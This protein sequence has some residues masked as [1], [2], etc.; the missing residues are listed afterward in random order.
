MNPQECSKMTDY[1]L[2]VLTKSQVSDDKEMAKSTLFKRYDSYLQVVAHR[3]MRYAVYKDFSYTVD[4]VKSYFI[5]NAF[6][7]SIDRVK[8]HKINKDFQLKQRMSWYVAQYK[9]YLARE[10]KANECKRFSE[11]IEDDPS[12]DIRFFKSNKLVGEQDFTEHIA[13]K[14]TVKHVLN[15]YCTIEEKELY[16]LITGG[17]TSTEIGRMEGVTSQCIIGRKNAL[18]EKIQRYI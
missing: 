8:L 13:M 12:Y 15:T 1:E 11:T 18:I 7:P 2:M 5:E 3:F 14:I 16:F 10:F 6:I 9:K 17:Y 4:D